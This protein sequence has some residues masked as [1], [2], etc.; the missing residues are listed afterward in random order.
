MELNTKNDL[1]I[2]RKL[3]H[4]LTGSFA[5]L[6]TFYMQWNSIEASLYAGLIGLIGLILETLRL[7]NDRLNSLFLVLVKDLAREEEKTKYSGL[8]YYSFGV[9][10][11]F[12]FIPWHF[13]ICGILSLIFIDPLAAFF[14]KLYGKKKISKNKSLVGTLTCFFT[15]IIIIYVYALSTQSF[16]ISILYLLLCGFIAA[17]SE[18]IVIIDDNLT[19]PI[20]SSTGYYFTHILLF[21]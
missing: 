5:L 10:I 2:K 16:E 3:W 12:Y 15:G 21:N 19:I 17:L 14:G 7:K 9:S 6:I 4:I 11:T 8:L 18:M 13:A 20:L 1:H